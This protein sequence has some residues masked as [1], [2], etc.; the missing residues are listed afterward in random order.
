VSETTALTVYR[1]AEISPVSQPGTSTALVASAGVSM[2]P[3]GNAGG[4]AG[5]YSAHSRATL[6]LSSPKTKTQPAPNIPGPRMDVNPDLG[7]VVNRA[8]QTAVAYLVNR[9][10][11]LDSP[12]DRAAKMALKKS[13][14]GPLEI[15]QI[16]NGLVRKGVIKAADLLL[17]KSAPK[18]KTGA[19]GKVFGTTLKVAGGAL[20]LVSITTKS[21]SFADG[22]DDTMSESHRKVNTAIHR[23]MKYS[24]IAWN[25]G[26]FF[27][28][29]LKLLTS[30]AYIGPII[31][32]FLVLCLLG[33]LF[34]PFLSVFASTIVADDVE[35]SEIY[36][37]ITKKE[38][39]YELDLAA[40]EP[41][42]SPT[43]TNIPYMLSWL[44]CLDGGFK[45][46]NV[47][48]E[49][50]RYYASARSAGSTTQTLAQYIQS[51][52][53]LD[54]SDREML[55]QISMDP[56]AALRCLAPPFDG[57]RSTLKTG[58][59]WHVENGDMV[60]CDGLVFD[61]A[62]GQPIAAGSEGTVTLAKGNSV[63]ISH[64]GCVLS[65]EGLIPSV[66]KNSKVKQGEVIGIAEGG[67]L[68]MRYSEIRLILG[69]APLNPAFYIEGF[70]GHPGSGDG[71]GMVDTA[72][73]E[74]GNGGDKY[75][76]WAGF[77][78]SS[79]WCVM[80]V[81]WCAEQNG[82]IEDAVIPKESSCGQMI[83]W[84]EERNL[85]FAAPTSVIPQAGD[86]IFFD[87][88]LDGRQNHIGIVRYAADG[89]VYTVEGNTSDIGVVAAKSYDLEDSRIYG[90]ATP[91][92]PGGDE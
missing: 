2:V 88:D 8:A 37:Y 87:W 9:G 25:I 86:L 92:Y 23:T 70:E 28:K 62:S 75:T 15:A 68:T 47:Q 83:H 33:S 38:C 85:Y 71:Q 90:Y 20:R 39:E 5:A 13:L 42:E 55:A 31:A 21:V 44:Y 56:F 74:V 91:A 14:S 32:C 40:L 4:G 36:A 61:V 26:K 65:Y 41:P 81:S 29:A 60:Y 7:S 1:K 69:N 16:G 22:G 78:S 64:D 35:L 52:G 80:F 58:F 79:E 27:L 63:E 51:N 34:L 49:I 77:P 19:M 18:A 82:L 3:S 43:P 72:M 12:R 84:Y 11:Y 17:N 89:V 57:A 59:G 6:M 48:G 45:L 54:E 67:A 76:A 24:K 46:S 30:L 66:E 50:D 73:A 10:N 53:S